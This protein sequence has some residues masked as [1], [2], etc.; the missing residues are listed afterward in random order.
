MTPSW[1]TVLLKEAAETPEPAKPTPSASQ[2]L[3]DMLKA[4][5]GMAAQGQAH[6]KGENR[7][8]HNGFP[9]QTKEK[10]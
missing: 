7:Y 9:K 2:R 10:A 6:L 4:I 8:V 3:R 1:L 5:K